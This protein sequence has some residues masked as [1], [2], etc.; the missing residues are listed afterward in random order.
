MAEY[1]YNAALVDVEGRSCCF[2][3][4]AGKRLSGRIVE[5]P[6]KVGDLWVLDDSYRIHLISNFEY[7]ALDPE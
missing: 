7:I 6:K 3:F 5:T 1:L 4:R 2:H